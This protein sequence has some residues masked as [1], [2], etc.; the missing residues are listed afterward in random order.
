MSVNSIHLTR[1]KRFLINNMKRLAG[2]IF[3]VMV[4]HFQQLNAQVLI[5]RDTTISTTT[6]FSADSITTGPNFFISSSGDVILTAK[7]TTIIPQFAIIKGGK[8]QVIS[9]DSPLS[10]ESE[11]MIIPVEFLLLQNYP[12]P[13]NPTTAIGYQLS[14][15]SQVELSIYN[16]VGQRVATLVS[17]RQPTGR[18]QVEWDA[19]GLAS[20]IYYYRI[21]AGDW[22]DMK[23]MVLLK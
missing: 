7:T 4:I 19:S 15:L 14:V 21:E 13:F 16:I 23:K 18:Y 2:I 6:S 5:L 17:Q 12:N 11:N 20:G 1:Q 10:A 22:R 8:F 3:I 9:G